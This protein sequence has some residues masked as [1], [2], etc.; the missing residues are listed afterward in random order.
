MTLKIQTHT[1]PPTLAS[2]AKICQKSMKLYYLLRFVFSVNFAFIK[3][4]AGVS[5]RRTSR[6]LAWNIFLLLKCR[7][8][9]K[10][11]SGTNLI[12]ALVSGPKTLSIYLLNRNSVHLNLNA[13]SRKLKRKRKAH[14][15]KVV[16]QHETLKLMAKC[17]IS[18]A[19]V[20]LYTES[21]NY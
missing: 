13:V 11:A 1:H 12:P 7:T 9:W 17:L 14:T 4:A 15:K 6:F 20:I 19:T 3:F 21:F 18:P 10:E 16:F 2:L 8:F 5:T